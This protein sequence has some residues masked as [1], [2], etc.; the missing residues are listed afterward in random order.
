MNIYESGENYLET[1]LLLRFKNG[2]VHSIEVAEHL[3]VSRASVS[4]AMKAL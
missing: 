4:F 2:V 1:I 3:G